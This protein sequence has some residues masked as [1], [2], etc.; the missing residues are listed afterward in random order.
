[1]VAVG[2][3]VFLGVAEAGTVGVGVSVFVAVGVGPGVGVSVMVGTTNGVT[4]AS[5][6]TR[7]GKVAVAFTGVIVV[8]VT[9]GVEAADRVGGAVTNATIPRQ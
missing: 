3:A 8:G 9:T 1:M 2:L 5:R 4:L 7:T 6:V